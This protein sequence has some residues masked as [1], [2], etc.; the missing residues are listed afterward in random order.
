MNGG[1]SASWDMRCWI[2]GFLYGSAPLGFGG[3]AV[4]Q[5]ENGAIFADFFKFRPDEP[6][7]GDNLARSVFVQLKHAQDKSCGLAAVIQSRIE[8]GQSA[9]GR[10]DVSRETIPASAGVSWETILLLRQT[11]RRTSHSVYTLSF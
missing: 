4:V 2:C 5:P 8:K 6:E 1:L 10:D 9:G 3:R 11:G 7:R